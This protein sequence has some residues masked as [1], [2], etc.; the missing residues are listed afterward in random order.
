MVRPTSGQ[1]TVLGERVRR[2][3][4]E[5]WSRVGYLVETPAACPELTV[6]ENVLLEVMLDVLVVL[7]VSLFFTLELLNFMAGARL[8]SGLGE[9]QHQVDLLGQGQVD[10]ARKGRELALALGS[11]F[12]DYRF[13][14]YGYL[15]PFVVVTPVG[16][17][18]APVGS[19]CCS[20]VASRLI[21]MRMPE[22]PM[23]HTSDVRIAMIWPGVTLSPTTTGR[24]L[25]VPPV[26]LMS[27]YARW[28]SEPYMNDSA[29]AV[30]GFITRV[31]PVAIL[32]WTNG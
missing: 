23:R 5:M 26:W 14:V 16:V 28:S 11:L 7:V 10:R 30:A 21:E 25:S 3:H 2:G 13:L 1:V 20:I 17:S 29:I 8:A 4:H 19:S 31:I 32:F 15:L 18:V 27:G 24:P 6:V 12:W 22:S 9:F